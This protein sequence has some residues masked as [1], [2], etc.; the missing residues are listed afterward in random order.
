[1]HA[2]CAPLTMRVPCTCIHRYGIHCEEVAGNNV[3]QPH[4]AAGGLVH[5]IGS[6][7]VRRAV[8]G[9][10]RPYGY[11]AH[12][13]VT[14]GPK[15]LVPWPDQHQ[16]PLTSWHFSS[17]SGGTAGYVQKM[18]ANAEGDRKARVKAASGELAQK[19]RHCTTSHGSTVHAVSA[20]AKR[21]KQFQRTAWWDL[22]G[23]LPKYPDVPMV[24]EHA[25]AQGTLLSF[26]GV[27][28]NLT[29]HVPVVNLNAPVRK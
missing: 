11:N 16:L 26:R 3:G 1:M 25:L 5:G 19:V 10:C 27:W 24:L 2:Y 29:T 7:A 20:S 18:E 22:A 15:P 4:A 23:P 12:C 17:V 28:D 14:G 9:T 13:M 8:G 21:G 6:N